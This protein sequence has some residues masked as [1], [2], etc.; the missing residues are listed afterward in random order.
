MFVGRNIHIAIDGGRD[1]TFYPGAVIRGTVTYMI[2][3]NDRLQSVALNLRGTEK[4][5]ASKN[6]PFKDP[7]YIEVFHIHEVLLNTPTWTQGKILKWTFNIALPLL[8]GP[9]RS[10]SAE[11]YKPG[12]GDDIFDTSSHALAPTI[13]QEHS[14]GTRVEY[15]MYAVAI[16]GNRPV[17]YGALTQASVCDVINTLNYSPDSEIIEES[18]ELAEVP[19]LLGSGK[20]RRPSL[21]GTIRRGSRA[22]VG[23]VGGP[24]RLIAYVP[25]Q[26]FLGEDVK[27]SFCLRPG[28]SSELTTCVMKQATISARLTTHRRTKECPYD[29]SST[30]IKKYKMG[31][32]I[33]GLMLSEDLTSSH[34]TTNNLK[35]LPPTFKSYSIARSCQ[36][37]VTAT[38][39][40]GTGKERREEEVEFVADVALVR[41]IDR[42]ERTRRTEQDLP[43]S[44]QPA[45]IPIEEDELPTYDMHRR[46]TLLGQ[47]STVESDTAMLP[48]T[49]R[50]VLAQ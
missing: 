21:I 24:G 36:L 44:F 30:E 1:Q 48:V 32:K 34:F 43:P 35:D 13:K 20:A 10:N 46:N 12:L 47:G 49:T 14:Q 15:Q 16:Y 29:P 41:K 22:S 39:I 9:D 38:I 18:A 4:V 33:E 8:T 6:S 28:D 37:I 17:S 5:L 7:E 19:F 25:H 31:S 26:I 45:T 27:I 11:F 23:S 2:S 40:L 3:T 50:P 42:A